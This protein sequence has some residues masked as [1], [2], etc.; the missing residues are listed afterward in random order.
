MYPSSCLV[1]AFTIKFR[2]HGSVNK[3]TEKHQQDIEDIKRNTKLS[4]PVVI[5][6]RNYK[7]DEK[8]CRNTKELFL[9]HGLVL[10]NSKGSENHKSD[11]RKHT[12]DDQK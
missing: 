5:K 11:G 4:Y 9:E 6:K 2:A 7:Q 3:L 1:D 12:Y 10:V 8:T